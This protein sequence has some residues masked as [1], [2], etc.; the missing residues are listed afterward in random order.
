MRRDRGRWIGE[1]ELVGTEQLVECECQCATRWQADKEAVFQGDELSTSPNRISCSSETALLWALGNAI[2]CLAQFDPQ[3]SGFYFVLLLPKIV[4]KIN[5]KFDGNFAYKRSLCGCGYNVNVWCFLSS[6]VR[7][8][9]QIYW[10]GQY[11]RIKIGIPPF[12]INRVASEKKKKV[13]RIVPTEKNPKIGE[14]K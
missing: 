1:F 3:N 4:E 7:L 10:K 12:I 8:K 5:F 13:L 11:I 9:P 6:I 14:Y 2:C